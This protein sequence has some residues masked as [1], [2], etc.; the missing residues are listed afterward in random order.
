MSFKS[1]L[2][3]FVKR[4]I[5]L[6]IRNKL[7]TTSE[8]YNI[9]IILAVLVFFNYFFK[10]EVL[11]PVSYK[12]QYLPTTSGLNVFIAPNNEKIKNISDM[13]SSSNPRTFSIRYFNS[14]IE[15]K[16]AYA[17]QSYNATS[18]FG[19]EFNDDPKIFPYEYKLFTS[20]EK[21]LFSDTKANI[22]KDSRTSRNDEL[23]IWK[24]TF[25][26]QLVFNGLSFLQYSLDSAIKNVIITK[27]RLF[28]QMVTSQKNLC[29]SRI[30]QKNTEKNFEIIKKI[31][32]NFFKC[33][34]RSNCIDLYN[35]LPYYFSV[36]TLFFC[37]F[38]PLLDYLLS[39]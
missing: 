8:L 31:K 5:K 17:N 21:E 38:T 3:G 34:K 37:E 18:C 30:T 15:M 1:Q 7:Q 35:N 9:S 39:I 26:N 23:G 27:Y 25:G 4:N 32:K 14:A 29:S 24:T 36:F 22:I 33:F 13:M 19:I 12:S 16:E 6:K 2:L 10:P 20:S 11:I 28:E